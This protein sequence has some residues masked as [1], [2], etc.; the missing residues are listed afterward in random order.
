MLV[1]C[2]LALVKEME[3]T[4]LAAVSPA[5]STSPP[6]IIEPTATTNCQETKINY[7]DTIQVLV[8]PEL[9]QN[10]EYL[11]STYEK[12]IEMATKVMVAEAGSIKDASHRAAVVWC[13]LNRADA[14][15]HKSVRRIITA[16][17]QFAW[18]SNTSYTK[19]QYEFVRD[20]FARWLLEKEGFDEVGRTLPSDYRWFRGDG[21][22]NHFRN[23][24]EGDY[25]VWDWS[26]IDPYI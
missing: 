21:R 11:V 12:E 23:A 19:E 24:Y 1:L 14:S 22:E 20:I 25:D 16:P 18:Y 17:N 13:I 26:L 9:K 8:A 5:I 3:V 15:A 10:V 2:I 7:S 4:A 6:E